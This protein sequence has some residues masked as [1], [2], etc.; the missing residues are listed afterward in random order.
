MSHSVTTSLRIKA[1]SFANENEH[2][3]HTRKSSRPIVEGPSNREELVEKPLA[4]QAYCERL[5]HRLFIG[6]EIPTEQ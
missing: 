5:D 6:T 3:E 4:I 1:N 2:R